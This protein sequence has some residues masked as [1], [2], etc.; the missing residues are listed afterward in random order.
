MVSS[1]SK[2]ERERPARYPE[3]T[4]WTNRIRFSAVEINNPLDAIFVRSVEGGGSAAIFPPFFSFSG[5]V[6]DPFLDASEVSVDSVFTLP[7]CS[8]GTSKALTHSRALTELKMGWAFMAAWR[9]S[10]SSAARG[11]LCGAI[12]RICEAIASRTWGPKLSPA[13]AP[14]TLR[15]NSSGER[16]ALSML[17]HA[18]SRIGSTCSGTF[19]AHDSNATV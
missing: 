12:L 6:F 13:Y 9:A 2:L 16:F 8:V 4:G 11:V 3:K 15:V 1:I 19:C 14:H 17:S 5:R 7:I 10:V 18:L